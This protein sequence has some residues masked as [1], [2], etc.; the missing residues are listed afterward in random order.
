MSTMGDSDTNVVKLKG[1]EPSWKDHVFTAAQLR[2]KQFPPVSY[3]VPDLIPEGL[4]ILACRPKIGKSWLVLDI[5]IGVAT[6]GRVLGGIHVTQG[7]VLYCALEDN[8]RRL[9]RIVWRLLALPIRSHA[10]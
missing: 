4:T 2:D 7:D 9:Q 5:A 6:E 10:C 3:V 8:P 1:R